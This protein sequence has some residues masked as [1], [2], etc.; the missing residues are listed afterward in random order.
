[1]KKLNAI[2]QLKAFNLSLFVLVLA[3]YEYFGMKAASGFPALP[4]SLTQ[5]GE[6]W[7]ALGLLVAALEMLLAFA[8]GGGEKKLFFTAFLLAQS[9]WIL[10]LALPLAVKIH[11]PAPH[12]FAWRK[13]QIL[14]GIIWVSHLFLY[15]GWLLWKSRRLA[16]RVST[17]FLA[18]ALVLLPGLALWTSQ[19][20]TSGDEPHY[21]LMAYSLVHD[22][23][24]DLSNNYQAGDYRAFYHRGVLEPQ[25]LEH[26]VGGKDYSHHPLGPVL[27]ILPGFAL[28]GRLGAS[29]TMAFLAAF[30]IFLT[31]RVLEE[32]GARHV[33]LQ[34]VGA[35][36]LYGSPLLLFSGLIFPEI[37]TACLVAAGLLLFARRRWV[38]LGFCLGLLLW[39]HNRNLL[40]VLPWLGLALLALWNLKKQ[41]GS[42]A[43]GFAGGLFIPL[44]ALA[45]YFHFLYGVFTPLGAHNESFFSLFPLSRFPVGFLGLSLDQECGLWFH[46]PVFA[47]LLA[48]V[49]MTFRL[50]GPFQWAAP[51]LFLFYYL[52][53]SFYENLGE[54]PAC[55]FMVGV[56]PLALVLIYPAVEKALKREYWNYLAVT[57]AGVGVGVNWILAAVPWARYNRLEGENWVLKIMGNLAHLPLT[58]LE[59]SFNASPVEARSYLLAVLWMALASGLTVWFFRKNSRKG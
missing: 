9:P 41:R 45:L 4:I 57:L 16:R 58:R 20:D 35:V 15:T 25:G 55:R 53:M 34:L 37:P 52:A 38:A 1:M 36:A 23:D 31:L 17:S 51:G 22:G 49:W 24:L 7:L 2:R 26:F 48:G 50:K 59:P 54:T 3:G 46:F 32:T 11:L 30:T 14:F 40:L 27:A 10:G 43:L 28:A 5:V 8:V 19:C 33:P 39:M 18:A 13:V 6:G 21:L 29:L 12:D 47:L 56:T 44:L 42:S